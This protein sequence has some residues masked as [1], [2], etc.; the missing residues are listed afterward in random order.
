MHR[1]YRRMTEKSRCCNGPVRNASNFNELK[2]HCK[3]EWEK[4]SWTT[5]W[6]TL[7]IAGK[8]DSKRYRIM[9][10]KWLLGLICHVVA[11]FIWVY[12]RNFKIAF[13]P[14]IRLFCGLTVTY[15][16]HLLCRKHVLNSFFSLKSCFEA[17][18]LCIVYIGVETNT[19]Y[20]EM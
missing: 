15:R 14:K 18:S 5:M 8:D 2:Q 1:M 20:T 3:D 12:L 9:L 7:V 16:C 6:E 17:F 13:F 10:N 11:L 4:N 19:S